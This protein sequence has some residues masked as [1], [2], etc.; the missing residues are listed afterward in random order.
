[1]KTVVALKEFDA[2]VPKGAVI[3]SAP[4]G[5]AHLK[6]GGTVALTISAGAPVVPTPTPT[7]TATTT[8]VAISS[9]VGLTS[10]QAQSELT[11]AGLSVNQTFAYSGSVPT[12]NVISQSPDGTSP[13]PS[14]SSITIVVSQG[15][16][17]VFIPNVYSLS[18]NAATTALENLQLKVIVKVIGNGTHVTNISPKVGSSVKRGSKVVITLG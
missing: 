11:G 2:S 18:R 14:G 5:G 9:Y 7:P 16:E 13:V 15:S 3:S 6:V 10:D 17:K 12:G 4:G 1:M 8:M